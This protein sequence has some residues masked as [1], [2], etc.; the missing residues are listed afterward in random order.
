MFPK[1]VG[2][3]GF[4]ATDAFAGPYLVDQVLMPFALAGGGSFTAVKLSQ[5]SL[6]A[7]DIVER[8]T[9]RCTTF[10]VHEGESN[11]VTIR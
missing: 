2:L 8:F 11:L 1:A 6:T 5:H 9:G 7:A 4:L 10:V 3:A